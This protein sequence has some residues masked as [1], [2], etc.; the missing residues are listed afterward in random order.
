MGEREAEGGQTANH[1]YYFSRVYRGNGREMERTERGGV[2]GRR[3]GA[4]GGSDRHGRYGDAGK[5]TGGERRMMVRQVK[6]RGET[7][8]H[9]ERGKEK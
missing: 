5:L 8:D 1:Y 4:G 3:S 9:E 7:G 6:L 2:K